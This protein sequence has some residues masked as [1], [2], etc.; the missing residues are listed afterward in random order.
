MIK[1]SREEIHADNFKNLHRWEKEYF[2]RAR[3]LPFAITMILVLRNSVKSLQNVVNEALISLDKNTVT[4]SAYSQAR[5][6]LKHTAFIALNQK[7]IIET[8]YG[9][10]DYQKFWGFRI[11]AVDGSKIVLPDNEEVC[12]E[13]GTMKWTHKSGIKGKK[14]YATA[15]VLYDVFNRV[16]LDATL[17]RADA[18]EV[19]L[20]IAH[21][22]HTR[23][24][25]LL[26]MDRGYTSY[27]MIAELTKYERDYVIRCSAMSF[28]T[29]RDMLAGEGE[30]SQ[31]VTLH[32]V[33]SK[34]F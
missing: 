27:R 24:N 9:D 7:A 32:L 19:D 11:L 34:L 1:T 6:K 5:Y 30:D 31:I 21:L 28:Q 10:D 12:D 14:P 15:S 33:T 4:A 18:Y 22:L 3:S 20:A 17:G 8:M 26:V 29:A 25:D 2:T 13:F 23:R 16:S